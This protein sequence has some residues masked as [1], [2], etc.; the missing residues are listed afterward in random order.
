MVIVCC[1]VCLCT[2]AFIGVFRKSSCTW[3]NFKT[4]SYLCLECEKKSVLYRVGRSRLT[5]FKFEYC[6]G[7]IACRG[8]REEE[9]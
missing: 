8:W 7:A 6:A 5:H 3:A 1:L 9:R 4:L 2:C